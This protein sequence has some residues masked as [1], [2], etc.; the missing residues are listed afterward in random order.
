MQMGVMREVMVMQ[1]VVRVMRVHNMLMVMQLMRVVAV[2]ML[3]VVVVTVHVLVLR[4][5]AAVDNASANANSGY[6]R[7]IANMVRRRDARGRRNA[8]RC[9]RR[10][11]GSCGNLR[12]NFRTRRGIIG[13]G[14]I[15]RRRC[16]HAHIA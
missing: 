3:M 7:D 13:A 4:V 15:W 1:F 2:D 8:R 9:L 11:R 5:N 12:G 14:R 10:V 16:R 6:E